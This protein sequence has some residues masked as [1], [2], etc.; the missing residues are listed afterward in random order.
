M[1]LGTK[2]FF[3]ALYQNQ[4]IRI[5]IDFQKNLPVTVTGLSEKKSVVL[6]LAD[7]ILPEDLPALI[8][9]VDNIAA[10]DSGTLR[11]R[12]RFLPNGDKWYLVCCD[13]HKEKRMRKSVSFLSGVILDVSEFVKSEEDDPAFKE[14]KEKNAA[15]FAGEAAT[16]FTEIIDKVY[17]GKIQEPLANAEGLY[18]AIFDEHGKFICSADLTQPGFDVKK[19]KFVRQAD[20]RVHRTLSASWVIA[21]DEEGVVEKHSDTHAL[22]AGVVGKMANAYIM[23]FNETINSERANKKLSENAEQ[24]ILLN[25]IYAMVLKERNSME[26]LRSVVNLTGEYMKL[27]RIVVYEDFPEKEKYKLRYEWVGD[28]ENYIGLNEFFYVDYPKLMEELSDYETYFSNNPKHVVLDHSFTSYIASNLTGDGKKYGIIIYEINDV[29]HVL[30]HS[31]KRILR[32]VSQIIA[33][34]LMRCKDSEALEEKTES[35]RYM[36]YH[37]SVLKIKNRTALSEDLKA[38]LRTDKS[39][40]LIAFKI[41]NIKTLNHLLGHS[42]TD[43]LIKNALEF[44][45]NF[46][47]YCAEIYRFSDNVFMVLLRDIDASGARDF[48]E[49]MKERLRLPWEHDGSEHFLEI[50]AGV[51]LYPEFGDTVD[52]LFRTANMSMYKAREFGANTYAFFAR[53]FEL[54]TADDYRFAQLLRN[55]VENNMEGLTVKFQPV[56]CSKNREIL[57][58]EA[59]VSLAGK[60]S[61]PSSR[62]IHLAE[63]MGLDIAIDKWILKK[64]CEFCKKMRAEYNPEFIVSVNATSRALSTCAIEVMVKKAISES[65]LPA[66][67]LAVEFSEQVIAANYNRFISALGEL[68]K[69]GVSVIIDNIGSHYSVPSLIRHSGISAVKAEITVFT[70]VYDEFDKMH[71]NTLLKLAKES[72]VFV[73]VKEIESEDQLDYISDVDH[74]QGHLYAKAMSEGEFVKFANSEKVTC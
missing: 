73:C 4:C 44:M 60:D 16:S 40:A 14:F 1:A 43:A 6:S 38:T 39:G 55:A 62:L 63:N 56:F 30:T 32:S 50:S 15:R 47:G 22:L 27:D 25:N 49:A 24:Q 51:A 68:R 45:S 58:C 17:L 70:G 12:C 34:I 69:L 57:A 52:E 29:E 46:E 18:S 54:P 11:I 2:E 37:D 13:L 21:S 42:C 28:E 8:S 23:L 33:T 74:Y 64:A 66:E 9:E 26:T 71:T 19:H 67:A 5:R 7:F 61:F 3:N 65:G 35:L 53:E 72:G 59:L 20:I 10:Q 31:E 41:T 48:C 36:A